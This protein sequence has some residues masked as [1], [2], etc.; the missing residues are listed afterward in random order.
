M[1]TP[2]R[3]TPPAA[4]TGPLPWVKLRAASATA[5]IFKRMI[6]EADPKSRA[7]DLVA[8]YDKSGAPYGVALYN[9]KSLITLRLLTRELAG[10][11]PEK[12][13][14]ERLA[15]AVELRRDLFK[16]D[17]AADAYRV[18]YDLG[19]G[20][21]GLVV[22]RYGDFIVLELYSL[23]MFRQ[24]D[25]LERLLSVHY[26]GAKF[27]RRS[28]EYTQSME[29]FQ[30]PAG[31]RTVTRVKEHGVAFEVDLTGGH[32]T[33][34]F[35]DQRDNRLAVSQLAAGRG[36]LDVCSYTGG[37]GLYAMKLGG[38]KSA[39]CVELDPESCRLIEKNARLNGV[40]VEPVCVD[41]FP[42]LRQMAANSRTAGLV[43]LDPYKMIASREGYREGRQK[44]VDLNRLALSVTAPGGILVTCSC[45]GMLSWDDFLAALRTAAGSARRRVEIFRKS[46]AGPDH[47]V[48]AD[49]PEGEYLKVIWCRV[50]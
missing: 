24:A 15:R 20:L 8:V 45:S 13:F 17:A 41:A 9:P 35:C 48:A 12:F 16:L 46:G 23:A 28:S 7:G 34:F 33:G 43:V 6:G 1:T 39:V 42:Y 31:P 26:P 49:H 2:P 21:P 36:V 30:L 10:F 32:K 29:G 27:V 47:P 50:L 14:A 11:T 4:H 40:K 18:V 3:P 5:N 37:F 25:L 19:D 22:D 44:Y 38:A